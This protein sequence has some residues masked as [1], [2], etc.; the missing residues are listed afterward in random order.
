MFWGDFW[1]PLVRGI[2]MDDYSIHNSD[3]DERVDPV[4]KWDVIDVGSGEQ[5]EFWPIPVINGSATAERVRFTGIKALPS[6]PSDSDIAV[7]DDIMITQFVA[8]EILAHD[9]KKASQLT[10]SLA[11]TSPA[12]PPGR[13]A[14]PHRSPSSRTSLDTPTPP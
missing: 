13:L 12:T 10:F 8:A 3:A 7:L 9:N 14:P 11:P 6:L 5:I 2:T 1:H 4:L